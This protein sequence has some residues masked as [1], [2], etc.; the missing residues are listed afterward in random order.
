[1]VVILSREPVITMVPDAWESGECKKN[2]YVGEPHS[3]ETA[4]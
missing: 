3:G 2:K 4:V 1:M